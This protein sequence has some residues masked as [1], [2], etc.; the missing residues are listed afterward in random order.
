[1]HLSALLFRILTAW[2]AILL[3]NG[4]LLGL[5][6]FS[7]CSSFGAHSTEMI[8]D[9]RSETLSTII[10]AWGVL[11]DSREVLLGGGHASERLSRNIESLLTFEA[12]RSG[13]L[14]ICLGLLLECITYFDV[15]V[16]M[17][18]LPANL[19]HCLRIS[20]WV[21]MAVIIVELLVTCWNVIRIRCR[22][23]AHENA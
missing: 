23:E 2:W 8:T 9:L 1:M 18:M 10:I 14:L 16:R 21:L 15:D 6:L 11:L 12:A 7:M 20:E 13:V 4:C 19:H 3:G 5:S 17:E 22:R